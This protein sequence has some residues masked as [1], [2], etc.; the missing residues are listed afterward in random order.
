MHRDSF[1]TDWA[2]FEP[3]DRRTFPDQSSCMRSTVRCASAPVILLL[4]CCTG[5]D[6]LGEPTGSP[7]QF[8]TALP[9][10]PAAPRD[11]CMF[12]GVN[13]R[14][15]TWSD[16]TRLVRRTDV[17]VFGGE[18][19]P[20]DESVR[21]ALADDA[22]A[23]FPP[24]ALLDGCADPESCARSAADALADHARV[25]VRCPASCDL[26]EVSRRIRALRWF[27][28]VTTVSIVPSG[29]RSL[30]AADRDRADVVIHAA[31]DR[32]ASS[33]AKR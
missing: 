29:A 15:L 20:A 33:N 4:A 27:S 32:A 13:G 6:R 28:S 10:N 30:D 5:G 24:V 21:K 31:P 7:M 11:L 23:A 26:A 9:V 14:V 16:L 25:F 3:F 19:G 18:G 17:I 8:S 22:Q 12:D 1:W 2:S